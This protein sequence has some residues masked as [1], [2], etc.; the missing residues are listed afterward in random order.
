MGRQPGC[1]AG[2]HR[3][4][5][6]LTPT[7]DD[8]AANDGDVVWRV[9]AADCAELPGPS[10]DGGVVPA[11]LAGGPPRR[12]SGQQTSK[13]GDLASCS[14]HTATG[15]V[16]S[17]HDQ[18]RFHPHQRHRPAEARRVDQFDLPPAVA[19]RH[20]SARRA[21]HR[22]GRGLHPYPQMLVDRCDLD[23]ADAEPYP[24]LRT[25]ADHLGVTVY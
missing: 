20:D 16:G 13:T 9:G 10:Q 18:V 4:D 1:G 6:R 14:V 23:I 25:A 17:G 12:T 11:Q 21:P 24:D 19:E 7:P 3:P 8:T 15:P 22:P 2:L 5:R